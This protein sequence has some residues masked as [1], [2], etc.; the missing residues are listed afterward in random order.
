MRILWTIPDAQIGAKNMYIVLEY[1]GMPSGCES[2]IG[3][4][5]ADRKTGISVK[6]HLGCCRIAVGCF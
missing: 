6:D 5:H 4:G 3:Q 1:M 2:W